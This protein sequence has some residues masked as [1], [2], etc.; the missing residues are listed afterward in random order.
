M[1]QDAVTNESFIATSPDNR[2]ALR[3]RLLGSISCLILKDLSLTA[4]YSYIHNKVKQDLAYT[5]LAGTLLFDNRVPESDTTH[6]Y[7]IDLNY[8]P[9]SGL[10]LAAAATYTTSSGG[11]LPA[12]ANLTQPVSISSFSELKTR[13][14]GYSASAEYRFKNGFSAGLRYRYS[15]FNDVLDNPFDD[16]NDGNAHIV[17]LTLSKKW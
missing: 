6:S 13:E 2:D 12:A 3:Q 15:V 11:F 17:L 4:G 10:S 8:L 7:S 1:E 9:Q 5:D 14:M 16:L